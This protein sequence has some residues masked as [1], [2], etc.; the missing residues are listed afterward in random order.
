MEKRTSLHTAK[1]LVPRRLA[2]RLA[3]AGAWLFGSLAVIAAAETPTLVAD[4][5]WAPVQLAARSWCEVRLP[6]EASHEGEL[7][8]QSSPQVRPE[9]AAT[10]GRGLT[11][12]PVPSALVASSDMA[13]GTLASDLDGGSN[14]PLRLDTETSNVGRAS[15]DS[16]SEL[17]AAIRG[18]A[19]EAQPA[20]PT[21][22]RSSSEVR[23]AS[24]WPGSIVSGS[25]TEPAIWALVAIAVCGLGLA[26]LAAPLMTTRLTAP[27]RG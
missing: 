8:F 22:A 4:A 27:K 12:S 2:R 20:P 6:S 21:E 7:A 1:R 3:A 19:L 11:T 5:S 16:L 25:R 9:L 14:G 17:K 26:G 10:S 18:P 23:S 13:A 15:G 24:N